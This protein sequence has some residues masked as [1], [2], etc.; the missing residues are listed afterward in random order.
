MIKL[1]KKNDWM[2]YPKKLK[3]QKQIQIPVS[4]TI[5]D[6]LELKKKSFRNQ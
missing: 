2:F 4:V 6:V 5:K 3:K 1:R